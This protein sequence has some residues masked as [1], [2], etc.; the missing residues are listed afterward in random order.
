M[1]THHIETPRWA[2]FHTQGDVGAREHWYLLHGYGQ[3]AAEFL[4]ICDVLAGEDRLL[5]APEG[6]SRFYLRRG[7]G[8]VGASWMTREERA[9]EIRDTLRYLDAVAGTLGVDESVVRRVLGFSQGAAAAW[10]WAALGETRFERLI[11]WGGGVPG[12]LVLDEVADR[13]RPLRIDLVRGEADD[14]A[15]AAATRADA[16]RLEGLGLR[17]ARH[18]F[19]GD[20]RM[21]RPTLEELART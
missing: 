2:R 15:D 8:P 11:A 20:H 21:D 17:C 12:D 10:R 5:V 16:G 13:L 14:W 18:E 19:D 6:L 7:T 9:T 3:Q 4:Q 1:R